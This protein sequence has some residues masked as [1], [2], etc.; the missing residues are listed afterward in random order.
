MKDENKEKD[1]SLMNIIKEK[2]GVGEVISYKELCNILNIKYYSG[3]R[4]KKYQLE[5]LKRFFNFENVDRKLLITNIYEVPQEV[6]DRIAANAIYVKYIEYILLYYLSKQPDNKLYIT[7]NELYYIL[8]MVNEKF[9]EY[10]RNYNALIE[11]SDNDLTFSEVEEF[12]QRC[13]HNLP[14]IL[15]SSL[16]SLVKRVLIDYNKI[17]MIGEKYK[18][19]IVFREADDKEVSLILKE[20][21]KILDEYKFYSEIQVY[22]KGKKEDYYKKLDKIFKEE[23][24]WDK[25]YQTNKIIYC[26][27][28]AINA[29]PIDEIKL[30]KLMLNNEVM[31]KFDKQS[32][33]I[34]KQKKEE[35]KESRTMIEVIRDCLDTYDKEEQEMIMKHAYSDV[36]EKYLKKQKYLT[37]TLIKIKE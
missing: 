14:D 27:E 37:D 20:K 25:V 12:Y 32:K 28:T 6:E 18:D 5:N 23:Y 22:L 26:K 3:G 34:Y 1:V 36:A 10:A 31:K 35:Q 2:I 9:I 13:N 21:R 4:Q 24:G 16:K 8:G 15:N 30:K 11:K 19:K 29:L 7:N 17:Y 33:K